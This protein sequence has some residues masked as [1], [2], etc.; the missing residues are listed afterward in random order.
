LFEST[1][2]HHLFNATASHSEWAG[3]PSP[4]LTS[5]KHS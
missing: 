5:S 4:S 1:R 2:R 3:H